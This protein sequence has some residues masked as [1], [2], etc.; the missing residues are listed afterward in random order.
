[1]MTLL[2][3]GSGCGK[4]SYAESMAVRMPMPRYYL[5]AMRPFGEGGME[6]VKKHRLMRSGKGFETIERYTDYASLKLP[7]QGGT[8]LLEC[9][10]NLTANEMY[11]DY[12]SMSDPVE[13]VLA[14]VRNMKSQC[15]ELIVITNDVG[16][17]S[18][19]YNLSTRAYIKALGR[20]N[21]ELAKMAD[22]VYELVAGIPIVLKGELELI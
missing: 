6:K 14:G 16:S 19:G 18:A 8:A 3:G 2:I 22:N 11:N 17:D 10:C 1:M 12:G 15:G 5:A 21:M 7:V 20:I 4:S 9:I 13:R